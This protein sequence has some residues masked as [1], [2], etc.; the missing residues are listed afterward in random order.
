[1]KANKNTEKYTENYEDKI[2]PRVSYLLSLNCGSKYFHNNG[3]S[4]TTG[5]LCSDCGRFIEKGT[6]EYF[7]TCG[8]LD[9]WMAIHNRRVKFNN[10]EIK[11]DISPEVENI[12]NT[13]DDEDKLI[14]MTKSEA[15]DFM[16]KTYNILRRYEILDTEA[17]VAISGQ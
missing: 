13:L 9:I 2:K 3:C 17:T 16:I 1:M 7:M 11:S 8:H 14:E 12:M 6:L 15:K 10:G 5:R 4:Y